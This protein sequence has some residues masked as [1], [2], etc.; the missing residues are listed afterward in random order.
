[1]PITLANPFKGGQFPGEVIV[2]A[3]RWYLRYPLA[4]EHVAELLAERGLAV[5]ASCV[6]RWVQAYSAEL[7]KRC[8][9][10]LKRTNKSYRVDETYIKVKGED[11]YLYRAVD[12][13][14]QTID[15]LLSAKRDAAGAKRF[16]Q[17]VFSLPAN[18]IPRVINV[19]KNP[20]YPAAMRTLKREGALPRRVRLRQCKY[21]NNIVEQ[22]HRSVKK[23][24]WLA[25]G[26]GSFQSA[27]RTLE[28][29]ETLN[30]IRKGR[31]RWVAK[32][33]IRAQAQFVAKL[34][35]IAGTN[36][37]LVNSR[38]HQ[39]VKSVGASLRVSAR[40][41]DDGVIEGLERPDKC[42]VVAVQW[43]PEDQIRRHPEQLELFR[44]F[45]SAIEET[46]R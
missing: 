5:D 23:R 38:H 41:S 46:N 42:F 18:P 22:D 24:T 33:D 29:I 36:R 31:V 37:W 3:V 21:L 8:W 34:F 13:T 14:G 39:A 44:A 20:A 43:H 40:A 15:F 7:N 19:D 28:G 11:K 26:Y 4:Y 45:R 25:K 1:M 30:M 10:H 35:G 27:W 16:F 32:G 17:K 2:Q 6:W 12:S 9:S